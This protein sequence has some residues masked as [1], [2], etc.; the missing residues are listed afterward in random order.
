MRK[1]VFIFLVALVA[2]AGL[3]T[4]VVQAQEPITF[5]IGGRPWPHG[6][7]GTEQQIGCYD[8]KSSHPDLIGRTFDFQ[9]TVT[10]EGGSN[11][12]KTGVALRSN[13]GSIKI[14]NVED[15]VAQVSHGHGTMKLGSSVCAY[16]V[17]GPDGTASIKGVVTMTPI[18]E[19][20]PK[21]KPKPEPEPEPEPTEEP[22]QPPTPTEEPTPEV[23]E[24]PEP[25]R[26]P[27]QPPVQTPAPPTFCV[28][29]NPS[30]LF[31]SGEVFGAAGAFWSWQKDG[32]Y[33]GNLKV[34]N[35]PGLPTGAT[36]KLT[37]DFSGRTMTL[38][39]ADLASGNPWLRCRI[40]SFDR[41]LTATAFPPTGVIQ[42]EV[43]RVTWDFT[44]FCVNS[45]DPGFTV[46]GMSVADVTGHVLVNG[47]RVASL[48]FWAGQNNTANTRWAYSGIEMGDEVVVM[49]RLQ[50]LGTYPVQIPVVD[51][52]NCVAP[53]IEAMVGSEGQLFVYPGNSP[54]DVKA[55][56]GFT[57]TGEELHSLWW[58]AHLWL[59]VYGEG[60]QLP[61]DILA[62]TNLS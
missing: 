40:D 16:V 43:P 3:T 8:L 21:P 53:A 48:S 36:L 22:T 50:G 24:T 37:G 55:V 39:I 44:P 52:E 58:D 17:F 59:H 26:R 13:G 60:Y 57:G 7:E 47:E 23:T 28:I 20:E 56:T 9:A 29:N 54:D 41:G 10:N 61:A 11:H 62:L 32:E 2:I 25:T 35:I 12:A 18:K 19:I 14:E 34:S 15:S 30:G 38:K 6:P 33:V 42:V 1:F 45:P 51:A 5:S 31:G 46:Y 49:L 4:S 27:T